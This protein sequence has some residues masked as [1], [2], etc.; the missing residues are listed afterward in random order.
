ME[1]SGKKIHF[2]GDS[3]T[4]G[5]GV[6]HPE[7]VFVERIAKMTGA[8]TRNYGISG[9]RISRKAG[10]DFSDPF[11]QDYMY[12]VDKMD[13]DADIVAVFG[14][15][16]DFGHGDA[17]VGAMW[18]RTP[19]TFYGALHLLILA[20]LERYPAAQIVF[21]TPLHRHDEDMNVNEVGLPLET[22]L[23]GFR[24]AELEVCRY[25][26]IPVLDLW[27]VSGMQPAVPVIRE[28]YMPDGL[29]PN[30][31]GHALLAQ[32]IIGFLQTL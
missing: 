11:D 27:A 8:V 15:T 5:V 14:G 18:D 6:A 9:T 1:L 17:K 29:H 20:L 31:A 24:N 12:R 10:V 19:Y 3:I 30:D 26:G 32:K 25:Y 4:Q 23:E 16:N 13:P 22:H 28:K 21:L 2:L 7:N